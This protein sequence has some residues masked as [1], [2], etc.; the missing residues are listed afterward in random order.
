MLGRTLLGKVC[1]QGFRK[2]CW[3][4][5]F[6]AFGFFVQFRQHSYLVGLV[7]IDPF[8]T[9]NEAFGQKA[10]NP[11]SVASSSCARLLQTVEV[12]A[13]HTGN[14]ENVEVG[15][16]WPN[17]QSAS[18]QR[19]KSH[20]QWK[21]DVPLDFSISRKQAKRMLDALIQT[22]QCLC[23]TKCWK[24]LINQSCHFFWTFRLS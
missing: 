24:N 14:M 6:L 17:G 5:E 3:Q 9:L 22:R 19:T 11:S 21:D 18:Y 1:L 16:Q 2:P 12:M 15:C 8:T 23:W 13:A 7:K 10:L 20:S 4:K